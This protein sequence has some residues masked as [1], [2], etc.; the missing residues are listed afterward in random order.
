MIVVPGR[1]AGPSSGQLRSP[2]R[3][4]GWWKVK[5]I[6]CTRP[7]WP[8]I[9]VSCER[10]GYRPAG[11]LGVA[12]AFAAELFDH[13]RDVVL[14]EVDLRVDVGVA[15][16]AGVHRRAVRPGSLVQ[17][18]G[19][20]EDLACGVAL[21]IGVG[22][23]HLGAELV[24]HVCLVRVVRPGAVGALHVR[25]AADQQQSGGSGRARARAPAGSTTRPSS[26]RS[27]CRPSAWCRA[28]SCRP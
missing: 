26:A 14:A 6:R 15:D 10:P 20:R 5:L 8:A 23:I 4:D 3:H 12:R 11:G 28:S 18:G 9:S 2:G 13:P 24:P 16:R 7:S 27:S 19:K 22:E 1:V 25:T 17:V 21:D